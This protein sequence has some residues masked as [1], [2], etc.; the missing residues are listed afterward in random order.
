MPHAISA[1]CY[2]FLGK[3]SSLICQVTDSQHYSIDLLQGGLEIP[4]RLVFSGQSKLIIKVQKLLHEAIA[5]GLLT[6]ELQ[7]RLLDLDELV[8]R[9]DSVLTRS[10]DIARSGAHSI[11]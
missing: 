5:S 8:Q 6:S 1:V 2:L 3:G 11:T 7:L 9:H 10:T 4:C